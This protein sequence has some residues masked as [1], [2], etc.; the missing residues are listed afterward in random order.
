MPYI[1]L[2]TADDKSQQYPYAP[3]SR[4]SADIK[5]LIVMNA[6]LSPPIVIEEGFLL[7][8]GETL[9]LGTAGSVLIDAISCGL[10]KIMS[11]SADLEGYAELRREKK[12]ASP[13]DTAEGRAFLSKLQAKCV[14]V[15]AFIPYPPPSIDETTFKRLHVLSQSNIV[16]DV[17]DSVREKLNEFP[18]YYSTKYHKG[19]SG[20]KW[21]ARSAWEAAAIDL[22]GSGSPATHALMT[23]AN[24]QR[25]L[26]RAASLSSALDETVI[27]ETGF[28][29]GGDDL[30]EKESPIAQGI[31]V[32]RIG[33]RRLASR[34]PMQ[35]LFDHYQ[36]V[37]GAL[38]DPHS[39]LSKAKA[40]WIAASE[41]VSQPD[42]R[43]SPIDFFINATNAYARSLSEA[44]SQAPEFDS[45]LDGN[46]PMLALDVGYG[47][48]IPASFQILSGANVT[49]RALLRGAS[50]LGVLFGADYIVRPWSIRDG[51]SARSR[52]IL[53][54]HPIQSLDNVGALTALR[55]NFHERLV[56]APKM[57]RERLKAV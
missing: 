43:Q 31:A 30:I 22:F 15:D 3:S 2:G 7:A 28:E 44:V 4:H 46:D 25:Q 12:H 39:D 51:E 57:A 27:V 36:M 37:F 17:F 18:D 38:A 41:L 34:L 16:L 49:R 5:T 11:R 55:T 48:A 47:A 14:K 54:K 10:I 35:L 13:P 20:G 52:L 45:R 53:S 29:L 50:T 40:Q 6:A 56:V 33:R 26:I 42:E 24:R 1:L 9:A 23:L 8:A 21:T 32:R 19:L